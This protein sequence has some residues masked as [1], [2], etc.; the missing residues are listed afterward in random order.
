MIVLDMCVLRSCGLESSSAEV[1]R[2]IRTAGVEGVSVPWMVMEE[3]SAQYAVKYRKQHEAAAQALQSLANVTPWGLPIRLPDMD[4]ERVREHWRSQWAAVVD[5]IPTSGEALREA[6]FREANA[7]SPCRDEGKKTGARD[8]AIWLSAI[9]YARAHEGETVYFVSENTRDLGDGTSY[10]G[11]MA[12]DVASLGDRFV[13]L[14]GVGEVIDRFTEPADTDLEVVKQALSSPEAVK[15]IKQAA[16][17][18]GGCSGMDMDL[19]E[20]LKLPGFQCTTGSFHTGVE[21]ALALRWA[22]SE[23]SAQVGELH[24]AESYRV[25]E[26]VWCIA[27][28][29]W[30]IGGLA[31]M[32][33]RV[34]K[35]ACALETRLL[36]A[37]H[38][39]DPRVT[40]L[41]NS[42]LQPLSETE[43]GEISDNFLWGYVDPGA[44]ATADINRRR[45][46]GLAETM[47]NPDAKLWMKLVAAAIVATN[48]KNLPTLASDVQ[49]G[50]AQA[51]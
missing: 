21:Q 19:V 3:L 25:G 1:L 10:T 15:T 41:R 31:L 11:A 17:R 9:E 32:E 4:L 20:A 24:A 7:L 27:T 39:E 47:T 29:R 5:V 28:V 8:A 18:L 35:A 6:A 51:G 44:P 40:V 33:A 34:A 50:E 14:T 36:F 30:L 22:V 46:E 13:H 42:P 43:F 2:A 48:W 38:S 12:D 49:M 26:Q 37:P 23:V 45:A 16:G